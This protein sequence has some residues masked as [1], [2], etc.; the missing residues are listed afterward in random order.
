METYNPLVLVL[1]LVAVAG[2]SGVVYLLKVA[3]GSD[4][5]VLRREFGLLF[6]AVGIFSLGGFI[7]L[8]WTDWAG[9]PAGHF[10]ELFGV[11]SGLFAFLMI[12]AGLNFIIG[13]ELRALAWASALIGLFLLQGA[14]A[15]LDFEM[16]RSP[17][18]TFILW[19]SAGLASIG[20]LPYAYLDKQR[21]TLAYLGAAALGIMALA[22]LVTGLAAFYDHIAQVVRGA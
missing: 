10:T 2:A 1:A 14:R 22:A 6:L 21:Q 18:M 20:M 15:V 12:M 16:T 9:F 11:T 7:Q 17:F 8:L 4:G 19:L 13:L 5:P 3:R